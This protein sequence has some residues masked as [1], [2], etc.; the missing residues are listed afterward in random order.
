MLVAGES[1]ALE[2]GVL[3]PV[4]AEPFEAIEDDLRVFISGTGFVGVFDAEQKL[5]ALAPG[6]EPVEERCAGAPDV[7]VAGRGRGEPYANGHGMANNQ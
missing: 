1:S 2:D 6:E 3:V 5:A 4:E 7:E